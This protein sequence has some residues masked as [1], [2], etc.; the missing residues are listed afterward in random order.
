MSLSIIHSR[1]HVGIQAPA[2]TVEVHLANGLPAFNIVG[3]PEKAVQES[4]ERVRGAINNSQFDFPAKRITVNLAPADLPKEGGGFDLPI[5]IGILAASG[6]VGS[7]TLDEYEFV[8]EL[9][10]SG[11]IRPVRGILP[12]ALGCHDAGKRLIC[13]DR[14][15]DEVSLVSDLTSYAANHLLAVTAHLNDTEHLPE[16][17]PQA[18]TADNSETRD[19]SDIR[20]QPQAKRAL[21]IAAAGGH[22]L[23]MIGPPGTG[24]SMLASRLPGILPLLTDEQ[25]LQTAS[26][27]SVGGLKHQPG[28]W[29]IPPFRAPHHSASPAALVGGGSSPKPGEISLAHNG[30]LFLD[31]LTE[32]ERRTLDF[33]REPLENGYITISR[34]AHQAEYPARFQ[35]IAAMN[36]CPC[37]YLGDAK[38]ACGTCTREQIKRYQGKISGPVLDRI[39]LHVDVPAVPA[40]LLAAPA[41]QETRSAEVRERVI[42]ARQKQLERNGGANNEMSTRQIEQHCQLKPAT[43]ALIQ[44]AI[45][46]LGLSAR[47]YHRILKVS[48]T[49]ADLA[50]EQEIGEAHVAEAI[51]YR[52]LD[53]QVN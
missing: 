21:E 13:P 52:R 12:V 36:P 14:N 3:L 45:D 42:N 39:D 44:Q 23:L 49:I 35:L 18:F 48:R 47:A 33:L 40:S 51:A 46:K 25:A 16:V 50:G 41:G 19:L 43:L 1:V 53:R 22:S 15:Q 26:I 5:A 29:R 20:G 10:L 31:E 24:K 28:Q 8:G 17:Q 7:T 11:A 27:H 6:Q 32:F 38:R 30:V 2:V 9:A 34:V 4:R 37:G